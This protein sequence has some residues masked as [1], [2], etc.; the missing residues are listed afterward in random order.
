[1]YKAMKRALL[2]GIN[3]IGTPDELKG[4]VNDINNI[5]NFLINSCGYP[6]NNITMLLNETATTA[7]IQTSILNLTKGCQAGDTLFFYYS[8]HGATFTGKPAPGKDDIDSALIPCDYKQNGFIIDDW[9]YTHLASTV[10]KGVS[11]WGFTDCCHSGT[12][13]DLKYNWKFDPKCAVQQRPNMPYK[14]SEWNN[15]FNLTITRESKDT[16]GD[17]YLFSGCQDEQTSAD[18]FISNQSQGA[19]TYCFLQFITNNATT[20]RS[21]TLGDMLKEISCS[22]T[23]NGFSQ[24]TQLSVG[25]LN[26]MNNR[27]NP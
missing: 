9:L 14:S 3:Y 6:A 24:R 26:D 12:M 25:E 27:F 20:F 19:F 13:F 7:N 16:M 11:L 8:G 10:P 1:M 15:N 5:R 22:L 17:V 18:A 4:C 21:K 23:I 2:I